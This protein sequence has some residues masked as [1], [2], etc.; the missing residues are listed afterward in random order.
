MPTDFVISLVVGT[1][2][3]AAVMLLPRRWQAGLPM[4]KTLLSA[5]VLTVLGVLGAMLMFLI[6]C[7]FW[8]GSSF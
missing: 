6:E 5:A 2:A 7:G 1:L 8:A 3:M 4:W